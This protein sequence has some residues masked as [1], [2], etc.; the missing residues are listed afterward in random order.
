MEGELLGAA[1]E[2]FRNVEIK[3]APAQM[4]G[5]TNI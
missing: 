5:L 4:P 3:T 1:D 2:V